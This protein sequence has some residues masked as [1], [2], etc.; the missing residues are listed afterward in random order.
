[1]QPTCVLVAHDYGESQIMRQI[2][3]GLRWP[4]RLLLGD[5]VRSYEDA[6]I[7]EHIAHSD[8]LIVAMSEKSEMEVAACKAAIA[9]KKPFVLVGNI[10]AWRM[11]SFA[12]VIP[13]SDALFVL[14]ERDVPL[15]A[16]RFPT[17]SVVNIGDITLEG[18][19]RPQVSREGVR[20]GLRIKPYEKLVLLGSEKEA[21]INVAMLSCTLDAVSRQEDP[22]K[23]KIIFGIHPGH[24]AIRGTS[25]ESEGFRDYYSREIGKRNI[26]NIR[27]R[28]AQIS[29]SEMIPGADIVIGLASTLLQRA[30]CQ[31]IPAI[32]L[33]IRSAFRNRKLPDQNS[34]WWWPC[35]VGAVAPVY[36]IQNGELALLMRKLLTKEGFAEMRRAQ[37]LHFPHRE[38][39]ESASIIKKELESLVLC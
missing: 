22:E 32:S 23:F 4:V 17:V 27:I 2:A 24:F 29:I 9:H 37:E 16:E 6:Q 28:I 5:G 38:V 33:M 25:H 35:D 31:R 39:G 7:A 1:M 3:E 10:G 36:D 12:D 20:S 18:A 15:A 19:H 8:L 14:T 26:R 34:G 21:D 30:A 13:S 11:S